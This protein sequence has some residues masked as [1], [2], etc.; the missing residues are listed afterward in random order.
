MNEKLISVILTGGKSS[1]MNN[2]NKS[3]LKIKQ[4]NFIENI[5]NSLKE[6]TSLICINANKDFEEYKY[7][8][9]KVIED[10][11]KGY[12]GPL[13]GLHSAMNYY[14]DTYE[15]VWFAIFPTDAP[16]INT[17]LI[18]LFYLQNKS[19][20]KAFICK[21]N[22]NI[23]PMFSFWSL[24]CFN[25]LDKILRENDGYKI[26]KFADEIGFDFLEISKKNEAEFF[27]V[28]DVDDYEYLVNL[29]K[30]H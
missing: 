29:I 8:G 11:I 16:I 6:K 27:N 13:A 5:V 15:N 23:E 24:D 19:K 25:H 20:V 4:I 22:N 2:Q 7:L 26:M 12:K 14:K 17:D 3:F 30:N 10:K 18:D 1:R 28:N 21:I 9:L